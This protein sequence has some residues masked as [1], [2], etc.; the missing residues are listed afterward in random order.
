MTVCFNISQKALKHLDSRQIMSVMES[1]LNP[2]Q[3]GHD[4]CYAVYDIK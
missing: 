4:Q 1:L 2:V 3:I